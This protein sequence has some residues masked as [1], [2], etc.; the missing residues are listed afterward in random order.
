MKKIAVIGGGASGMMAALF[1]AQRGIKV[2]LYE[3]NKILGKKI[4][5]TGKGRCNLTNG[6]DID[7]YMENIPGN[8]YFMY[9]ALYFLDN[10][11]TMKLFEDA[12][13]PVKTER[14]KR[15]Y[16]V[17]DKACDVS[18]TLEKLIRK[19]G[20]RIHRGLPVKDIKAENGCVSGIVM[21]NGEIHDYDGVILATGGLSYPGTGSDGDG[22][23]M[24]KNLG[25]TVTK[26]Y[27]S[28]VGLICQE[29]FCGDLMGLSLRNVS[30]KIKDSK[31]KTVY[32]DFGEMLFT[33]KGVSGPIVLSG[34]R[35]LIPFDEKGYKLFID[36]KPAL[37]EQ[38]LDKRILRDFSEN[39]NK[40]IKN[41]LDRL[42]P[43]SLI[44]VIIDLSEIDENKKV[45]SIS[46]EERKK[47]LS[48]I[49][50]MPLTIT[51]TAGY[52]EAVITSGG[53]DVDEIN[54]S[55]MESKL[56]KNLHF[57]GEIIDVD[58]YTGGFNLQ[59]AFST[60]ALAGEKI[61]SEE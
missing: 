25:H 19:K 48:V 2:H 28:L 8:P 38:T 26:L 52:N 3:K 13:M 10:I 14:G 54:P 56:I 58:A 42:L 41:A 30:I 12:G 9:S 33:H 4:L 29:D 39:T 27:P 16:P 57:A 46:K 17:S 31:N 36:L 21:S 23:R 15:V 53:V 55:T 32:T 11:S 7:D 20:V 6:G 18:Y 51:K 44:P 34:S 43:K 50:G 1:A 40:S 60:G 5:I 35:S 45:N 61:L 59:I 24:A 47:L 37:D 49:K 22:Y